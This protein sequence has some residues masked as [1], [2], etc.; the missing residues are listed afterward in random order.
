MMTPA[1]RYKAR[2]RRMLYERDAKIREL[3]ESITVEHVTRVSAQ[4]GLTPYVYALEAL[5]KWLRGRNRITPKDLEKILK[6]LG[7][8]GVRVGYD[9]DKDKA[10]S[11]I[12]DKNTA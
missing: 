8:W 6:R 1:Q 10:L 7:I 2:V 4:R 11:I 3:K 5:N 12:S 9:P